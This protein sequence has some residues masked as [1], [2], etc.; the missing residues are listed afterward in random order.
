MARG[1]IT[2]ED[3]PLTGQVTVGADFGAELD[4]KSQAHGMIYQLLQAVLGTAK[5][6]TKV[7]D[8]VPELNPEPS[9]I[10]VAKD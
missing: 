10:I 3:D 6:F 5:T 8:T 9:T 1:T 7:E 2:I 4:P